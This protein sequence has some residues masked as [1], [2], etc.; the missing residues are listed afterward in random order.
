VRLVLVA[1]CL[2]A[3]PAGVRGGPATSP[4]S[5]GGGVIPDTTGRI[6]EVRLHY[7]PDL[8]YELKPLYQ[9]LLIAL[10]ADVR[11]Q[12]LCPTYEAAGRFADTWGKWAR[13]HEVHVIS[14]GR[15]ISVWARDRCIARESLALH[16]ASASFVPQPQQSYDHEKR[17]DLRVARLLHACGWAP[18]ALALR[19][20][21]EGGNVVSNQQHVF[22]GWNAVDENGSY[23]LTE[24]LDQELRAIF[25]REYI[26]VGNDFGEVPWCHV[27]M[28]LT[29]LGTDTVLV[30]NPIFGEALVNRLLDENELFDSPLCFSSADELQVRFDE[31]ASSICAEGYEVRRLPALV[32]TFDGWM[33]SYNN[34][35]QE[36]RGGQKIVYMPIYQIAPL[37]AVAAAIYEGLGCEVR[38]VDVSRIYPLGGALRCVVNVIQRRPSTDVPNFQLDRPY[39][40]VH[41]VDL[42]G[43][44]PTVCRTSQSS[45]QRSAQ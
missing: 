14:V 13:E 44:A 20:H 8:H 4:W 7:D 26:L 18:P 6:A 16:Q 15:P 3:V 5:D 2:L 41:L 12:V 45:H 33:I 23:D 11:I 36:D 39:R 37:D 38:T 25:G 24:S 34:V 10:P 19:L 27:D 17:N 29:P 31:V 42:S 32:S 40:G 22:V 35:V 1:L 21:L 28:Y 9:D 30:A 43:D